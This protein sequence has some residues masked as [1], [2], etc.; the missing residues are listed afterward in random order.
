L[1]DQ[2]NL[3]A[4]HVDAADR[5]E[6]ARQ[7]GQPANVLPGR[8]I[9][10]VKQVLARAGGSGKLNVGRL[11]DVGPGESHL[12]AAQ[13]ERRI[14]TRGQRRYAKRPGEYQVMARSGAGP[15][16]AGQSGN[17]IRGQVVQP[18]ES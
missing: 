15:A 10:E 12:G 11:A 7:V 1:V 18:N 8:D 17:I 6:L 13:V 5:L 3:G 9:Q 4:E 16:G 14:Q 2:G